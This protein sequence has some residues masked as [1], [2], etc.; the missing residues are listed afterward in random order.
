MNSVIETE[1]K[2]IPLRFQTDAG[3]FSPGAVDAGTL[4][5]L[6]RVDFEENDKV[7]DLGCG[8]GVVGILAARLI[9]RENVVLCD[10]SKNAVEYSGINARLNQVPGLD[11][12]LSD[13]LE[14]I[15]ECD[16]TLILSNPPYHADFSVAKHFIEAGFRH[17]AVAGRLVM[18]TKRLEWYRNKI[19]SVFGG[20]R[21]EEIDGYYVFVAEKRRTASGSGKKKAGKVNKLSR[22]LQRRHGDKH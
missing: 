9:G 12:R 5:M 17:L 8:Y 22:K 14:N 19:T 18:V 15:P 13:G 3:L 2:N 16:F 7:L 11:V 21:V 6:S 4:A 1:I 20:V 10:S